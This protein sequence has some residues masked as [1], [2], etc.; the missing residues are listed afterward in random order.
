[1]NHGL[2]LQILTGLFVLTGACTVENTTVGDS[3]APDGG[4]Q[5]T[6]AQADAGTDG[7]SPDTGS[8]PDTSADAGTPDTGPHAE[9]S[10]EAGTPEGG[11]AHTTT[12]PNDDFPQ[13][14]AIQVGDAVSGKFSGPD[15]VDFFVITIPAGN[16]DGVLTVTVD[17]GTGWAAVLDVYDSA[18]TRFG[19][20]SADSTTSPF[21]SSYE[22]TAGAKY[23]LKVSSNGD[24]V[25]SM[26]TSFVPVPDAYERNDDFPQAKAAP[27]GSAFNVYIFA[28]HDTNAGTDLDYF[29]LAVPA[30][31][32][33][34][35][36]SFTN[37][38]TSQDPQAYV[39]D[40]YDPSKTRVVGSSGTAQ[41]NITDSW[42][43]PNTT[44]GT[45]FVK[46]TANANSTVA[47]SV[48]LT[49]Q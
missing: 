16:E 2:S 44:G 27:V 24:G 45:Y 28:G 13:A 41:A 11:S 14:N 42:A 32:T 20:S 38:S 33:K 49:P 36:V 17:K 25:Y 39:L 40:L 3:G 7:G 21:V 1:M 22:L 30:N 48:T 9:A 37:N 47:S 10:M 19:G 6:G 26:T 4:T 8:Q 35:G 29:T 15:D 18:K 5:D 46:F 34:V 43:L 31:A 12:E 23:Y